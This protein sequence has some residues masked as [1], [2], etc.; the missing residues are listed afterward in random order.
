MSLIPKLF[1][2]K[3]LKILT[4]PF[5]TKTLQPSDTNGYRDYIRKKMKNFL[6][7]YTTQVVTKNKFLSAIKVLLHTLKQDYLLVLLFEL[8]IVIITNTKV[9][10]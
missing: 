7:I 4:K 9:A 5:F 3:K 6:Y 1:C 2:Q 10:P 8:N